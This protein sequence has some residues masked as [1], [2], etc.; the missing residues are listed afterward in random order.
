MRCAV[1][2]WGASEI[3]FHHNEDSVGG[4]NSVLTTSLAIIFCAAKTLAKTHRSV[5]MLRRL[6][7]LEGIPASEG[8]GRLMIGNEVSDML[9]CDLKVR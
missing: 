4:L 9:C 3:Q 2:V 5:A 7:A 1:R 6:L 8:H